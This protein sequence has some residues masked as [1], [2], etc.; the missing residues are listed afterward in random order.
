MHSLQALSYYADTD[1]DTSVDD[2]NSDSQDGG[3]DK[4][5][6]KE[7]PAQ[8]TSAFAAV[9]WFVIFICM[10]QSLFAVSDAAVQALLTFVAAFTKLLADHTTSAFLV[11]LA[12]FIPTSLHMLRKYIQT[13]RDNF[14]KYVVCP[15]CF[16]IYLIE[17]CFL[18]DQTGEKVPKRCTFIRF[19]NH[20]RAY[21]RNPC[22]TSMFTKVN[23]SHGRVEYR[24]KYV[25]CYHSIKQ[26]FQKLLHRPGFVDKLEQ[27]RN[28]TPHDGLLADVYD[29]KIWKEF[30]S[31][32]HGEFLLKKRNV[33]VMLNF[34]F[35]QPFKH[36]QDSYGVLYLTLMNLPQSERF[37]QENVLLVGV[38]PAFEHEPTNLNSFLAPLVNDL[39]VF[40][41]EGIRLYTAESPRYRLLFKMALLCVACDI[42]AARKCCGFKGH[43]AN[44]G[45]S[46]CLNFFPGRFGTKDFSGFDR[47]NWPARDVVNHRLE[48]WK[49]LQFNT[50]SAVEAHETATGIKYSILIELPYFDPIRFTIVDPMHNLFLGTAKHMMKRVWLPKG[51]VTNEQLNL[52][53]ARVDNMQVPSDI[54]RVPEKIATSFG[55]FTADQWKHWTIIYSLY[56]LRDILPKEHYLCWQ[57]F[58]LS[59]FHLCRR[60]ISLE[61]IQKADLLL[62]KF[63]KDVEQ[64]YGNAVITP[65]MHLHCHLAECVKDYGSIYGFWLF[66]YERYNGILGSFPT[67]Q[68]NIAVQLMRRFIY[69]VECRT[70]ILPD[71]FGDYFTNIVPPVGYSYS[72]SEPHLD[73][74]EHLPMLNSYQISRVQIPSVSKHCVLS[75]QDFENLKATYAKLYPWLDLTNM[76]SRIRIVKNVT[77]YCQRFGSLKSPRTRKSSNVIAS[78]ANPDGTISFDADKRPGKVL[79]YVLHK[80]VYRGE[81][82]EHLFAVMCWFKE[83]SQ[84]NLFGKP[85]EV[86][87]REDTVEDGPATFLPIHKVLCRYVAALGRLSMPNGTDE[88]VLFVSPFPPITPL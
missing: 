9:K 49:I 86:W 54:G 70:Q 8:G 5:L 37:K 15:A 56:A 59:C 78:W 87:S 75:K 10:W 51:V 79:Y 61:D 73:A 53:Q 23:L 3:N 77:M 82:Q 16:S 65:N 31:E 35:F 20:T 47:S 17:D 6:P 30:C 28:R 50:R 83:H 63:C 68:K 7:F 42:P 81:V 55:G 36:L 46:R 69:E 62:L 80:V 33:G 76:P 45:C 2:N 74:I 11:S 43:S 18:I 39:K 71:T 72:V 22:N 88:N 66:S 12:A 58:V 40:W 34:D 26:S 44:H 19:P 13:N 29:G 67:N 24:P 85:L 21:Y 14:T 1:S 52:I 38:I 84:K 48:A 27:W 64:L 41:N 57:A 25:Y 32:K 60:I 4:Q